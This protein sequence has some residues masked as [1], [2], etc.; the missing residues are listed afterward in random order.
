MNMFVMLILVKLLT[1]N[2]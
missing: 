2:I 1:I